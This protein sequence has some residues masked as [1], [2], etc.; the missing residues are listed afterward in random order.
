MIRYSEQQRLAAITAYRNDVAGVHRTRALMAQVPFTRRPSANLC[1]SGD[2][3]LRTLLMH[4]AR[5]VVLRSG[6][7]AQMPSSASVG[8]GDE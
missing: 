4:A 1:T 6:V 7:V 5:S 2:A 8:C 3:C